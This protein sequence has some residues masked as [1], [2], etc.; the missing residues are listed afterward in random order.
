MAFGASRYRTSA[1]SY[2]QIFWIT[3]WIDSPCALA[4]RRT[5][6][7]RQITAA[8]ALV[9]RLSLLSRKA[10]ENHIAFAPIN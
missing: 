9:S 10:R 3:L 4:A 5:L 2:P 6:G 1:Q 7:M 8:A